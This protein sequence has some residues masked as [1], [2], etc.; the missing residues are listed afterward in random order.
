MKKLII[1]ATISLLTASS[2]FASD[3]I[4]ISLDTT[5]LSVWGSKTTATSGTGLIGKASTGVGVGMFTASTGYA[6][7]TQHKNGT[8]AYGSSMDS[9]A[10][11]STD[12][13]VGTATD[14]P[15]TADSTLFTGSWTSM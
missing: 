11:Y 4:T 1:V 14:G 13:T 7:I 2:A 12:V 9:T 5:G 3:T 10:I 15:T 8:K 6:A